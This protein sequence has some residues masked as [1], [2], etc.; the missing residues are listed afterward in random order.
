MRFWFLYR[1]GT[2]KIKEKFVTALVSPGAREISIDSRTTN[3]EGFLSFRIHSSRGN[4]FDSTQSY[5]R[6]GETWIPD[7]TGMTEIPAPT[8][9][10]EP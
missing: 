5:L 8:L 6:T 4:C 3:H 10:I 7:C 1:R 9:N 2:E